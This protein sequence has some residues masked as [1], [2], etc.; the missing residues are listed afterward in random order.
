MFTL[1]FFEGFIGM[2]YKPPTSHAFLNDRSRTGYSLK[3]KVLT[4]QPIAM[5]LLLDCDPTNE[6]FTVYSSVFCVYCKHPP[7][8]LVIKFT[9][10]T[11]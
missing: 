9:T 6:D 4:N 11:T 7:R 5:R 10:E 1:F 3:L 2:L 8:N